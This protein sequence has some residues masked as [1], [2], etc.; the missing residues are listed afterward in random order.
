MEI[1]VRVYRVVLE[2]GGGWTHR[3]KGLEGTVEEEVPDHFPIFKG[4]DVKYEEV[5]EHGQRGGRYDPSGGRVDGEREKRYVQ[6]VSSLSLAGL[7]KKERRCGN[8][9]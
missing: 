5:A 4:G 9:K 2:Q 7:Y 3:L 8:R 6:Q 1:N